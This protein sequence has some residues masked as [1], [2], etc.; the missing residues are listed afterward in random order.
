MVSRGICGGGL[1]LGGLSFVQCLSGIKLIE[2]ISTIGWI[3][4]G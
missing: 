2:D 1:D 4:A 3:S